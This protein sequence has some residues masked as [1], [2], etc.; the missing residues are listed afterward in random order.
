MDREHIGRINITEEQEKDGY[1][2]E[3]LGD[4]TILYYKASQIALFYNSQ[5]TNQK[6]QEMI[7]KHKQRRKQ[8]EE[9]TG[10]KEGK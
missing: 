8:V 6:I 4:R 9:K 5:E 3:D 2:I 1:G 7:E 10:W